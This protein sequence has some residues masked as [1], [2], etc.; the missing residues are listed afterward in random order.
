MRLVL[1][2]ALA[3]LVA[4]CVQVPGAVTEADL[5]VDDLLFFLAADHDHLDPLQHAAAL[6]LAQLAHDPLDLD[7][8]GPRT[9]GEIDIV[10]DIAVVA[11]LQPTGGFVSVDISDPAAPKPLAFYQ[12]GATYAGD[13]KLSPDGR[14]AFV[15]ANGL[16]AQDRILENPLLAPTA[17]RS[18]GVHV[19]DMSDPAM[20]RFRSFYPLPNTG[21]HMLDVH[22]IGGDTYVFSVYGGLRSPLPVGLPLPVPGLGSAVDIAR[23]ESAPDGTPRL[24]PAGQYASRAHDITVYDDETLG[25]TMLCAC[26][27][28]GMAI[29]DVKDPA[30]PVELGLWEGHDGLYVHTA[31]P[32]LVEGK[33]VVVAV[34]ETFSA[35]F[36]QPLW[37]IDASEPGAMATLG[38][39]R[40]PGPDLPYDAGYRFSTHNINILDNKVY[41]AHF[42]AGVWVLD[43]STTEKLAEPEAIAYFLAG[44]EVELGPSLGI[45]A[46]PLVWEA[47]PAK[48]FVFVSDIGAGLFVLDAAFDVPDGLPYGTRGLV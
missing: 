14:Y 31:M 41:L 43:I 26:G 36:Q 42:H 25:A 47:I 39:W 12:A 18:A 1:L 21:V 4:G 48:G 10:G 37:V 27:T 45:P 19:V 23:L 29:V 8:T 28:R 17:S 40:L 2:V 46:V 15:G 20:P 32:A 11:V 9:F 38:T 35:E 34:P 44:H 3:T 22:V 33:R 24:L 30:N 7:G 5:P 13:V 6:G 16:Y